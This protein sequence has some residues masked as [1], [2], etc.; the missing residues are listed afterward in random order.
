MRHVFE[1]Q[2]RIGAPAE[3]VFRWH[4]Q[5]DALQKLIPPG[6]PI[7]IV[8]HTGGVAD[9]ARVE[10]RMGYW[11]VRLRWVARHQGY[12]PGRRFEDVQ[13]RG[14]FRYW[15]HTHTVSPNGPGACLLRDHIEY[16][17]PFGPLGELAAGIVRKQLESTFAYRHGVT[18][19]ENGSA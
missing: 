12:I 7:E 1:K 19:R 8:S 18:A 10:L 11:P 5:S 2:T 4:E 16:E 15:K 13:E 17:L 9:G 3:Q 6:Q 14:P